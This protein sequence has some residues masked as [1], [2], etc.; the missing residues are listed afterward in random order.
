[1]VKKFLS[2][3]FLLALGAIVAEILIGIGYDVD[4]KLIAQLA[5]G[6]AGLY[7]IVEGMIDAIKKPNT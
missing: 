6:I 1:M 4:P 2:R 7:I 5:V 3:K